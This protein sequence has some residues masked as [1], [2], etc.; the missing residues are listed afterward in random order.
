MARKGRAGQR[1]TPHAGL[2]S[3][4]DPGAVQGKNLAR[5]VGT[6]TGP[7]APGVTKG[8]GAPVKGGARTVPNGVRDRSSAKTGTSIFQKAGQSRPGGK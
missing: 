2:K 1:R 6:K 7:V 4:A 5:H 3:R 8:A